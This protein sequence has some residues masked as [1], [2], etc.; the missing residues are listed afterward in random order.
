MHATRSFR[1]LVLTLAGSLLAGA[2]LAAADPDGAPNPAHKGKAVL[3]KG[4]EVDV[5]APPVGVGTHMG[6]SV[7]AP[8]MYFD[9][10]D[11]RAVHAWFQ[12]HPVQGAVPATWAIGQQLP[13][14][15]PVKPVPAGL[16]RTIRRQPPGFSYVVAGD[17]ILI[18]ANRSKLVVDGASAAGR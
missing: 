18:V 17:T 1:W 9:D 6:S 16:Q 8:G 10:K 3:G 14:G 2:A 12:S 5:H 4:A 11:R 7:T 13:P 15:T